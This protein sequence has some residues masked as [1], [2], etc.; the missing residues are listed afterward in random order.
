M[1]LVIKMKKRMT[2][3]AL[4]AM[5]LC[6]CGDKSKPEES[7][8]QE[9]QYIKSMLL[10]DTICD[11]YENPD[12]YLGKTYHMSGT[13]YPSSDDDGKTIYSIYAK[14]SG[15]DE[16]IGLELDWSDYSG[17]QSYDPITVE[18]TLEQDTG[19]YQGN[20]VDYLVLRVSSLEKRE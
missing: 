13:L 11:M 14:E 17:L 15:S 1:K 10:Y 3:A 7:S 9:M 4:A 20:E 8:A 19:T 18:G 12:D 2:T 5:L 16:G 6:A